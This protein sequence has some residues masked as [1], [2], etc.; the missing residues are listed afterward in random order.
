MPRWLATLLGVAL[1]VTAG[2]LLANPTR[3]VGRLGL[4]PDTLR[5][6]PG[7]HGEVRLWNDEPRVVAA[8]FRLRFDARV[9]AVDDAEPA[10]ASIV[11]G[12]NAIVLPLRRAPGVVEVPGLAVTGERAMRPSAPLYRF[13]VRAL[14]PGTTT[15][16]IEDF[17]LVDADGARR[18]V[19][20]ASCAVTVTAP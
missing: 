8:A 14:A 3:S 12:G 20:V 13:V 2:W 4:R 9:L 5:L 16:A 15:L 1:A 10:Y 19:P 11:D 18:T 7:E 17:S 6:H